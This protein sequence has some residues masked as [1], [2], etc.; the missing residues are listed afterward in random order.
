NTIETN[1]IGGLERL[2]GFGGIADRLNSYNHYL[3]NPGFLEQDIQRY[4]S[5]TPASVLAFAK[6][7]LAP[8]TRGVVYA[9]PGTPAIPAPAPATAAQAPSGPQAAGPSINADEPWRNQQP[10]PGPAQPLQL[11]TPTTVTLPNGL[12]LILSE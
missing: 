3:K 4:R 12:T 5:V 9:V 6:A 1:I 7:N 8:N 10:K 11:A 2:G